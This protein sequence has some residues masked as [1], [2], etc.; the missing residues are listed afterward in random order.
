MD[1]KPFLLNKTEANR[2]ILILGAGGWLLALSELLNPT[3]EAPTGRW[4]ILFK[5]IYNNFGSHGLALFWFLLGLYFIYT[6]LKK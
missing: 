5:P 4:S 6:G 3:I 1:K 2:F